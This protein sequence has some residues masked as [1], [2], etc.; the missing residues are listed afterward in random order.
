M[1]GLE[2]M[3]SKQSTPAEE[4][5]PL[6]APSSPAFPISSQL[7]FWT[8][9]SSGRNLLAAERLK[10]GISSHGHFCLANAVCGTHLRLT[11]GNPL[12]LKAWIWDRR[13]AANRQVTQEVISSFW[14]CL[15][16]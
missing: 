5:Q 16:I 12:G 6:C 2:F 11:P 7:S 4:T 3:P 1:A 9:H 15:V 10:G 14:I 13:P 8:N